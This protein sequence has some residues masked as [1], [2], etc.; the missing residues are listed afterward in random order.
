V[1]LDDA[2]VY[3]TSEEEFER[4]QKGEESLWPIGHPKA[5]VS[6]LK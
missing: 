1:W 4:R 2:T 6:P 3:V 5:N